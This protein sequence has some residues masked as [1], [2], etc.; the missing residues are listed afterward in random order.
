MKTVIAY[1]LVVPLVQF[2]LTAGMWLGGFPIAISLAWAPIALRTK[3][4]GICGGIVG[5]AVPVAFAYGVFRLILGPGSFTIGPFL[6][7]TLPLLLPIWNDITRSRRVKAAR[8]QLLHTIAESRGETASQALS[9]ET[10]TAH[11]SG[12]VGE[13]VGLVLAAAWF[14][15]R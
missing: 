7:S 1:V 8:E 15:L 2:C 14:C 11:G 3:V 12:V 10:M 4:A 13:I 6:A 5:V 9:T